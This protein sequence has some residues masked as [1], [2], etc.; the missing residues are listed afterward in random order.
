MT[1]PHLHIISLGAGVQ[2]T[3]MALMAA[4][5]EIT[6]MPDCAIFADTQWEPQAVYDHLR[7]LM[8]PNVLPYPVYIVTA[9]NIR[10]DVVA[11]ARV[12][13][14]TANPPFFT[15]SGVIGE[16]EGFL[17]RSC[18]KEYKIEPITAK[19]RDLIGLKPRQRAPKTTVVEQWMGISTDEVMRVRQSRVAWISHRW[20]LIESRKSRSDCLLWMERHGYPRPPKSSCI[21][22][23]FHSD[24]EWRQLRDRPGEWADAIEFDRV[25]RGG[26]KGTRDQLFVHRSLVPLDQ[27]DLST[28]EDRGQLNLFINDC[29]GMCGV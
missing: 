6:P 4:H 22:C 16:R 7:W 18:T 1:T 25:V 28:A 20:P 12:G 21:G 17:R 24:E 27:V 23:P 10:E 15:K 19:I 14:R 8:S 11:S 3:A 5:G 29:E 2:S 9:G 26:I 13:S